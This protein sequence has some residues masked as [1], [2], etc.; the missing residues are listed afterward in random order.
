MN[1]SFFSKP[2]GGAE[3]TETA[4]GNETMCGNLTYE[5]VGTFKGNYNTWDELSMSYY[6]RLFSLPYFL[7]LFKPKYY[8]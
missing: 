4:E 3:G 8:K 2:V 5:A 7:V 6:L 1:I